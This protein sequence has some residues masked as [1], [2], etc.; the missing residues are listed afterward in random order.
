[1]NERPH[2]HVSTSGIHP[3]PLVAASWPVR[4]SQAHDRIL[5]VARTIAAIEGADVIGPSHLAEANQHRSLDR[6]Y[7]A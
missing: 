7:W 5:K 4:R 6:T 2:R 3:I 1:M